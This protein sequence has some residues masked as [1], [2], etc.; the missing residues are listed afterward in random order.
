MDFNFTEEQEA[1]REAAAGVFAGQVDPD[2]VTEVEATDDRV[3]RALWQALARADLLGTAE[4]GLTEVCLLLEEQGKV[5][6]PVP[7]WATLALG[8][9]PLARFGPE[10]LKAE[11]LPEVAAGRAMLTGALTTAARAIDGMPVIEATVDRDGWRLDGTEPTV[12]QAHI[13]DRIL[14]PARTADGAV[15]VALVDPSAADVELE[16]VVTTNREIHPHL[17]LSGTRIGAEAV[18]AGT[19]HGRHLLHLMLQSGTTGL[20][21]LAVG[22]AES[23]L[24]QTAE[25]LNQRE[26][27]GK[28][29]STFQG[30]MLR[31]GDAYIDIEAMR[32]TLWQAA[33]RIDTGRDARWA[34]PAAKWQASERGQRVVHSTQHLHGGIGADVTYPIHRYFL[35]GKQIELMLGSGSAQLARL[36]SLIAYQAKQNA[37]Q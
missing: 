27:F 19:E 26:Q 32:V 6:A 3:D 30:A 21:A 35:W 2:R 15:M 37:A 18:V 5:V 7:L 23:A 34:V 13:A 31:A 10:K 33:W 22:V 12:P 36:G 1:V 16:R 17:H 24:R 4:M 9:L 8:A 20:C 11:W 25:Y 14:V 29:L 28:P